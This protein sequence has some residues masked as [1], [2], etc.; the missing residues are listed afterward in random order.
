MMSGRSE[1]EKALEISLPPNEILINVVHVL[2]GR[3]DHLAREVPVHTTVNE[4]I[5]HCQS[6]LQDHN[7][8]LRLTPIRTYAQRE[9]LKQLAQSVKDPQQV[10]S[11]LKIRNTIPAD[12]LP[13]P[14]QSTPH[15]R[16]VLKE[17]FKIEAAK[18]KPF[19]ITATASLNEGRLAAI[20]GEMKIRP[21]DGLDSDPTVEIRCDN[22]LWD[23]GAEF[24][25]ISDDL[26]KSKNASFLDLAVHDHYR[27]DKGKLSVQVDG[28]FSLSNSIFDTATMFVVLP[29]SKIPNGRSGVILGQHFFMNRMIIETTPR[30]F[31][32]LRG[33]E[34]DDTIWG[35]IRIKALVDIDDN[36]LEYN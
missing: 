1:E 10:T 13:P 23:T 28:V 25:Y 26:V 33:E 36:L 24:C 14:K 20:S 30:P 34:I 22:C 17:N 5:T 19:V 27:M 11:P 9:K 16:Q 4:A 21:M 12:Q 7:Q 2:N 6:L 35:E 18:Q 3:V 31:L 8:S 29:T 15:T 32:E